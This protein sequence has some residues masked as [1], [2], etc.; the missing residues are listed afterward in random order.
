MSAIESTRGIVRPASDVEAQ[1]MAEAEAIK[2][3]ARRDFLWK[4][5]L[6]HLVVL[7]FVLFAAF[8]IYFLITAAFR[9][10]QALYSTNLQLVPTSLTLDNFDHMINHTALLTWLRNS[11]IVALATTVLSVCLATPAAYAF[12]R[13]AFPGR[14]GILGFMLALQAFPAILALI[15]IF[16]IFKEFHMLDTL[17]GLVI[18]YSAGGLVFAIWNTKGYFDTIPV[19][20]EEAARVDGATPSQAFTRVILPLA[21]PVIAVTALLGFMAGWGEY[22]VAQTRSEEH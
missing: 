6:A 13:W 20:L 18:C 8:P 7:L 12:S 9:P 3:R 19:D 14:N 22:I 16:V 1:I 5:I 4:S 2:A 17:W 11:I 15:A 10:G 21:R